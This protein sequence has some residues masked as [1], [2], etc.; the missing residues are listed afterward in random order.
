MTD[1]QSIGLGVGP[2]CRGDRG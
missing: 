1:L 2:K